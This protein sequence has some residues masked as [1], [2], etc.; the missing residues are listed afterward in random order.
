MIFAVPASVSKYKLKLSL[1]PAEISPNNR[2]GCKNTECKREGIKIPKGQIRYGTFVTAANFQSWAW[3]HWYVLSSLMPFPSLIRSACRGCVTPKQ[4]SNLKVS[5][6]DDLSQ[7]DGYEELP[8]DFQEK[9]ARALEQGH[10]DDDD[11]GWVL[12]STTDMYTSC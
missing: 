7:L 11:W 1:C 4:I 8:E 6:G 9:V 3:K 10:I 12:L 2:A 5:I